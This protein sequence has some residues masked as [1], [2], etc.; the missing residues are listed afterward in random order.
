MLFPCPTQWS[1]GG[2]ACCAILRCVPLGALPSPLPGA[3]LSVN[4][5]S[6]EV[7]AQSQVQG[8][9]RKNSDSGGGQ[10]SSP[11]VSYRSNYGAPSPQ[12]PGSS[13]G[14]PGDLLSSGP[15]GSWSVLAVL[16]PPGLS[17]SLGEHKILAVSLVP[18]APGPA[19]LESRSQPRSPLRPEPLP[20]LPPSCSR[21]QLGMCCNPLGSSAGGVAG[22]PW[23]AGDC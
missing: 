8:D 19:L 4:C 23:G 21:V 15:P 10:L 22:S 20:E 12:G 9:T 7:S 17:L 13:R 18:W 5:F 2:G 6:C 1:S 14:R 3:W 11:K 16:G